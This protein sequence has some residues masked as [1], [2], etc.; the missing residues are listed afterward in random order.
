M[1]ANTNL[2][3]E[4]VIVDETNVPEYPYNNI[5]QTESG[6]SFEMDDTPDNERVRVQHRSGTFTEMQPNGDKVTK[7]YGSNYEVIAG[8]NDVKIT[9]QCNITISGACVITVLGDASIDVKG[10]LQQKVA[11]DL[12]QI[13][14]GTAT[15]T[16]QSDLDLSS[17]GDITL[18]GQNVNINSDLTVSGSINSTGSIASIGNIEAGMQSSAQLGFITPG[19]ISAGTTVPTNPTPGW[20]SGIMISDVL[21]TMQADRMIFDMH[22]HGGVKSGPS[23]T[24]GPT[25]AM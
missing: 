10:N 3:I 18:S 23:I 6:H 16:S 17:S 15:I 2:W 24:T 9:G 19:F 14:M 7:V 11:G 4:P 25:V 12:D 5:T 22:A 20:I 8:D 21:R 13:V 1:S